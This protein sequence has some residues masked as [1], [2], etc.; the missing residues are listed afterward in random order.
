MRTRSSLVSI[1]I[2]AVF[3]MEYSIE[4]AAERSQETMPAPEPNEGGPDP[5]QTT[6]P[7]PKEED[8]GDAGAE[9]LDTNPS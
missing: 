6:D 9:Q 5:D 2:G 7:D 3:I 8:G 1:A 4:M